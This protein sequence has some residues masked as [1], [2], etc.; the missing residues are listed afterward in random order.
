MILMSTFK[1]ITKDQSARTV[2]GKIVADN[3]EAVLEELRK[4]RLTIVSISPLKEEGIKERIFSRKRVK[5]DD[6]VIFSRQLATMVE[7]GVPIVEA[8][9]VLD[10]HGTPPVFRKVISSIKEDI[11]LGNSL[12]AAF[13][14]HPRIFDPLFVNMIRAGET[15][16]FLSI[17]LDRLATYMEKNSRLKRKVQSAMI[18]PIIVISMAIII[19]FFLLIKVVPIFAS[20]YNSFN[21]ELPAMTQLLLFISEIIRQQFFLGMGILLILGFIC[22]R[23]SSTEK[24]SLMIDR[25]KLKLPLF[26][27]LFR[28]IIVGRFSRTLSI[29]VRS[30]VPI[31]ESL[32]IVGKGCGNRVFELML[33]QVANDVREGENISTPLIKSRFFPLMMTRMITVG[34]QSGHLDTMLIKIAEFYDDQ[35]DAAVSG[36]TSVIEPVLIAFLGIVVGFIVVTLF[37]PIVNISTLF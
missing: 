9:D 18:Y 27:N 14:K 37:L 6:L 4:R 1:Y 2:T 13:A 16:G 19:T 25:I 26:G 36:L 20:F 21:K 17:I 3:Q 33:E 24:G 22:K 10:A 5:L 7:A 12:S 34:E 35:V 30:G 23:F 15:G 29:L 8:L 31:L 11:K 28:K 32:D